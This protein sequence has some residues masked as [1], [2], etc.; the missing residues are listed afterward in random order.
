METYVLNPQRDVIDV[1]DTYDSLIWVERYSRPGDFE[2]YTPIT[3]RYLEILKEDNYLWISTVDENR[4][5]YIDKVEIIT[6]P[7]D[8]DQL[9][10]TGKSLEEILKWRVVWHFTHISTDRQNGIHQLITENI[11]NPSDPYR[12]IEGFE[13]RMPSPALTGNSGILDRQYLG[14]D[15]LEL[16]IELCEEAEWGWK[17]SWAD[18]NGYIFQLYQGVD[19][20]FNQNDRPW[21]VFSPEYDNL[22]NTN[23]I[24]NMSDFR[25]VSRVAG[26]GEGPERR[27]FQAGN[28][29]ATGLNRRETFTDAS[30]ISSVRKKE[31]PNDPD[32]PP[33]PT[34]TYNEMLKQQGLLHLGKTTITEAFDGSVESQLQFKYNQDYFMGDV[35]QAEN[36]YG[37]ST[38]ARITELIQVQNKD[39]EYT[40]IPTF[41]F[42][43]DVI[44]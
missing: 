19:R 23:Y 27:L 25:N 17:V 28:T 39:G 12:R 21:I 20:S 30:N 14:E 6:S 42:R 41:T 31:N 37:I 33:W 40:Q 32:L 10:V 38:S 5:M 36:E 22:L 13:V 24:R 43:T 11:I 18:T 34:A 8:G 3:K 1:V 2:L 26:E 9:L 7:E 44:S 4:P 15:L 16:M 29:N 35:V